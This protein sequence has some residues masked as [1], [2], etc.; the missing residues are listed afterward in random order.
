MAGRQ[1]EWCKGWR[2]QVEV[3]APSSWLGPGR[4]HAEPRGPRAVQPFCFL[5][6][7]AGADNAQHVLRVDPSTLTAISSLQW[8]LTKSVFPNPQRA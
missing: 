5:P 7:L 2:T 4:V 6:P 3:S 8:P 1:A